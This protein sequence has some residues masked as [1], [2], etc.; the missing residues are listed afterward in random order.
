MNY[1]IRQITTQDLLPLRQRVLKP[2][3]SVEQCE[4]DG[5]YLKSTFHFG[6]YVD[7][8][9]ATIATFVQEPHPDFPSKL[10]YRLRGMAT[11]STHQ[12]QGLGGRLLTYGENFLKKQ[13]CD[14]IWFNA[15]IKA[16][17]FY[18]KLGFQYYGP[19]FD[20][21]DIGPHKVMYK[22]LIPR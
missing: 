14:F 7:G 17:P 9:L 18:E 4:V 22:S 1:E 11:D 10:S 15:R 19:L 5:D 21:K 8:T 20:I 3:L 16:F 2:F 12:G 13:G 6:L